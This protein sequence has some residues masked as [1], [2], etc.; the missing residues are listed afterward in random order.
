LEEICGL[1]SNTISPMLTAVHLLIYSDDPEA[2]RSFLR[3]VLDLAYVEHA[4]SAPGWRRLGSS[5][6][7]G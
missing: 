2:T 3:E 6:R 7:R 4:E 1:R 5:S